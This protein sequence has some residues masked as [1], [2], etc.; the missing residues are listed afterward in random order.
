MVETSQRQMVEENLCHIF[1]FPPPEHLFVGLRRL[2]ASSSQQGALLKITQVPA[3]LSNDMGCVVLTNY[4]V[5]FWKQ[6]ISKEGDYAGWG[7]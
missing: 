5:K 1:R 4:L 7:M 3:H 6:I 2:Q